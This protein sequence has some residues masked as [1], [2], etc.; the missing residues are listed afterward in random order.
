MTQRE[1]AAWRK[2][3]RLIDRKLIDSCDVCSG[4]L[5]KDKDRIHVGLLGSGVFGVTCDRCARPAG[6]KPLAS[7]ANVSRKIRLLLERVD[8]Q[9]RH[10][11]EFQAR[12]LYANAVR[13]TLRSRTI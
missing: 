6:L 1:H 10:G 5:D 13:E 2:V 3:L 9:I 12:T 11:V 7:V 8:V 4:P